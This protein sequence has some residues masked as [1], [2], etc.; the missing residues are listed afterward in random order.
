MECKS[1]KLKCTTYKEIYI[2]QV[3]QNTSLSCPKMD[4]CKFI[5]PILWKITIDFDYFGSSSF[6]KI[7]NKNSF[8]TCYLEFLFNW[9]L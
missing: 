7:V 2:M 9:P 1:N 8:K 6:N 3:F 4:R 5:K